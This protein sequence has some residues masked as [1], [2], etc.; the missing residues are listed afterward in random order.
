MAHVSSETDDPPRGRYKLYGCL[1]GSAHRL[2]F[3][4]DSCI[5]PGVRI[6]EY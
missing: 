6:V 4:I 5:K 1:D 3:I 2:A